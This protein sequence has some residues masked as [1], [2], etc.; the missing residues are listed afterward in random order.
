[1]DKYEFKIK[2]EQIK[3]LVNK[4]DYETAMKIA[5]TIDWRRVRSTSLLT[6][7]SSIYE[8]NL[9]YQDAK[10]ILL[11][12][13]ERAPIG[14]GLLT[15][16]TDLALR[17]GNV[18][19]A[20]A[21]Y[22]EYCDL[23]GDEDSM[24][25]LL[26]YLILEAKE[27]P[28]EQQINAL[29]QYCQEEL[30]D[31][32]LYHLA[33]LYEKAGRTDECVKA[34]DKIMLMFG[35]GKYV[36]KAMEMKLRYAPLNKY[37][38]D[39][40]ENRE[41]Y[42]QKLRDVEERYRVDDSYDEEEED[43]YGE[44]E[45]ASEV[46]GI[47]DE[48]AAEEEAPAE[49]EAAEEAPAEEEAPEEAPAEEEPAEEA[50]AEE[51]PAEEAAEE[52]APA[53][54][55]PAEEAAAEEAPAEEAPAEEAPAEEA[56]AEEAP[57]EEAPAEEAAAEEAAAEEAA[58]E[59]APAEE[60]PAEEALAEEVT[61]QETALEDN[62]VASLHEAK[63]EE[64]LAREV[65]RIKPYSDG[66]E[67]EVPDD[68]TRVFKKVQAEES[69]EPEK[70]Q[71][72]TFAAA[73]GIAEE[74]G[75]A[76]AFAR[77]AAEQAAEPAAE[78][79][80]SL[81]DLDL[82]DLDE[83]IP[84]RTPNRLMVAA[85]DSAAGLQNALDLLKKVHV[86]RGIKNAAA[87]ISGDKLNRRGV[88]AVAEKLTGKDLIIEKAGDLDRVT[89]EELNDFMAQTGDR[90]SVVLIDSEG[91]LAELRNNWPE[92]TEVFAGDGKSAAKAAPAEPAKSAEQIRAEE[93]AEEARRAAEAQAA[94]AAAAQA[95][96]EAEAAKAAEE[97][98]QKE[99]R[100]AEESR[101]QA[102]YEKD[103]A[104]EDE[105]EVEEFVQY[106]C[107]YATEIDCSI[108][109]KSKLALYERA[110]MME[111]DGTPLTRESA[112]NLIEHAADK[113]EKKSFFSHRYDKNGLLILKEKHFF[114]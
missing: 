12:A 111:E 4:G 14:R 80:D 60:A 49:E 105:M 40:V 27:A 34:C 57:A 114:D 78:P 21:Y 19:E 15:K 70:T 10:D 35:I 23:V 79:A 2:V 6:M 87:K 32:W 13:Y 94:A 99:D 26:R 63:A 61:V 24:Q 72:E 51:A 29:E 56:A 53:E 38:M 75:A 93:E 97:A 65:S 50:P 98:R 3:K 108:D 68:K 8:K 96:K 45:L 74:A 110:E 88:F 66:T 73:A 46:N 55:A 31:K 9:E 22:R 20:E 44:A 104:P 52:E 76:A 106:A 58:A 83:E 82:D 67:A 48:E 81:E 62:L 89:L 103:E 109:G 25:Y 28:V 1:M 101:M 113:A 7:A 41:K 86:E 107:Q 95:E 43:E 64:D 59:E 69:A 30:D 54:E 85:D 92:L 47:M 18:K 100:A 90:M 39:L 71:A 11:I 33:E 16:L 102:R 42:E 112:V 17:E 36:D 5:D 37:Q 91:A 84:E 77:G